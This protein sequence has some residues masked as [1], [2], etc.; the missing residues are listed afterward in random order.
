MDLFLEGHELCASAPTSTQTTPSSPPHSPTTS[1]DILVLG[2]MA[3]G[4]KG[5]TAKQAKGG[6]DVEDSVPST[7]PTLRRL[8]PCSEEIRVSFNFIQRFIKEM[9][10]DAPCIPKQGATIPCDDVVRA[11]QLCAGLLEQNESVNVDSEADPLNPQFTA[12]NELARAKRERADALLKADEV[13]ALRK[14]VST[15]PRNITISYESVGRGQK[16]YCLRLMTTAEQKA[17]LKGPEPVIQSVGY[18]K[19]MANAAKRDGIGSAE[20]D[21]AL[22]DPK[23]FG[24]DLNKFIERFTPSTMATT[25]SHSG[26]V[27]RVPL[28]ERKLDSYFFEKGDPLQKPVVSMAHF[29]NDKH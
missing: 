7:A 6:S 25:E 12:L 27:L 22:K 19:L 4:K 9:E 21:E 3:K 10:K 23:S 29:K 28:D 13:G 14:I 8:Q 15:F 18:V 16:D 26:L 5:K 2:I 11:Q 20:L 24:T 1:W 17:V